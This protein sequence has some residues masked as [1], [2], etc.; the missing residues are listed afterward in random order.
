MAI[1]RKKFCEA[2][3]MAT[4][5]PKDKKLQD[6]A[7]QY[8]YSLIN[9]IINSNSDRFRTIEEDEIQDAVMHTWSRLPAYDSTRG[10]VFNYCWTLVNNKL[11]DCLRKTNTRTSRMVLYGDPDEALLPKDN[12][13]TQIPVSD[14]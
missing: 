2:V 4:D 9:L 3:Q 1:D 11:I 14:V 5:N 10:S 6:T 12:V 7:A 13:K 8:I